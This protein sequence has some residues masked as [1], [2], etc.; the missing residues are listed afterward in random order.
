MKKA[1]QELVIEP[2]DRHWHDAEHAN[3]S[4]SYWKQ[5][6][7]GILPALE[8]PTDRPRPPVRT[9]HG[10]T[11]TFE[12]PQRLTE[13]LGDLARRA[14]ATPFMVF[15]SAFKTLLWRYT[16][17]DDLRVGSPVSESNHPELFD[18][19]VV[20]RTDLA[21]N[22]TFRELLARVRTTVLEGYAHQDCRVEQLTKELQPANQTG[23]APLFQLMFMFESAPAPAMRFARLVAEPLEDDVLTAQLD[24]TLSLS[25]TERRISGQFAYNAELFDPER[26]KRMVGH[27]QTLLEGIAAD[28][29]QRLSALPLLT[30]GERRQLLLEWN[31]TQTDFAQ[32]TCLHEL[33]EAQATRTPEAAAL[34]FQ[35]RQVTYREL[36]LQANR[37]AHH[38]RTL[39]IGPEISVAICLERSPEMIVG[40]LAVLKAG[41]AYVPLDPAYPQERL[42][43]MLKDARSPVLLSERRLSGNLPTQGIHVI[44]LEEAGP[45]LADQPITDPLAEARS[46]D[47]AYIIYTSGSTG[48]PKG[49]VVE[50]RNAVHLV[51]SRAQYYTDVEE[52]TMLIL[53]F[54]FDGSVAAIFSTLSRGGTLILPAVG[55]E[56]N[57]VRLSLWLQKHRI[58]HWLS[59]PALYNLLLGQP[60]ERLASLRTVIVAGE[61]CP[62]VLVQRHHA[63]VP[64]AKL[65]NEYGPTEG[66][67][68]STVFHCGVVPSDRSVPIGRPVN[69]VRLYVLDPFMNPLPIGVPGELYL[70]GAGL[71]RGYFRRP[72]LTAER[73]VPDPFSNTGGRLYKTGDLV[74][75]LSDGNVEFLGRIDSQVK[76]R[77]YRVEL[78]EIEAALCRNSAISEAVVLVRHTDSNQR[79]LVAYVVAKQQP[80]PSPQ[81]LRRALRDSLPDYMIPAYFLS[82][83]ALPMTPN[84]KIDH[85]ALPL[86]DRRA[87]V[88]RGY[89]DPSDEI[90][91]RLAAIWQRVFD[92]EPIGACD[93]FFDLGGDSLLAA[94]LFAHIEQ[95]FGHVLS[96][97]LLLERPTVRL[98]AAALRNPPAPDAKS[99]V[100]AIQ[101]GHSRPA[102]FCL[103][104]I[105]GNVLEFR[106]LAHQLGPEQPVYGLRPAGLDD[107]QLPHL[108]VAEMAAYSI[109]QMRIVQPHGPYHL[110]GYSL[111]GVV[112]FEMAH[113]LRAQ[114]Q[115]V[116]LLALLDS[117]LA[118][119][120]VRL[121]IPQRL[122][123]H[124][125]TLWYGSDGG[126]WNYLR[127]RGRLLVERIGRGSLRAADDDVVIGLDLS[128]SSRK[129][130][131]LHWQ[132]LCSYEPRV[133]DGKIMLFAARQ[134]PDSSRAD[135]AI[136]PT[137]GWARWTTKP[138]EV[139][140]TTGTHA[141]ILQREELR[142][143]ATQ[144]GAAIP[145]PGQAG[146]EALRCNPSSERRY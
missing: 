104:G 141:E 109:E 19:I 119:A 16:A 112:A 29:D 96:L 9:F 93:D 120:P 51:S 63:L 142:V 57:L 5:K 4:L 7:A 30:A 107:G 48:Q 83:E 39:G 15:L 134:Y 35:N 117:R 106:A 11:L 70:A 64:T 18:N 34:I 90:E 114:N 1:L 97:D 133:Y 43:F 82:V 92:L 59:V 128:H 20:L 139:C 75:Y 136:D 126:R 131:R 37:L 99:S 91:V 62:A 22:P 127:S 60:A 27:L 12:L 72:E 78:G 45:L 87:V 115:N 21:G 13:S 69:N 58:T 140:L 146:C 3:A 137:L 47:A 50:H 88:R 111:G 101:A 94:A 10:A 65:F 42:A 8:L 125:R 52:R 53:S 145:K 66:T 108:T 23:D 95:E 85:R 116:A 36:N 6:L 102:L 67:V 61:A 124:G 123:L 74:S 86:P 31:A 44:Y 80:A 49:V 135:N 81:Q 68:W 132:A 26:V 28:P 14:K 129:V 40:V 118:A 56:Q 55:A 130:A 89:A 33:F 73:F 100:V 84:G 79:H 122:R 138:V 121:S 105:G 110:A 38:L 2:A 143:L 71:A 41:G 46:D 113:Q 17:Q 24:M 32:E 144:L 77:G 76:I 103:P 54:A 25:E 98:L